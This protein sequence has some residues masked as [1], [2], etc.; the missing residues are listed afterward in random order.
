MNKMKKLMIFLKFRITTII[1]LIKKILLLKE[2]QFIVYP[3]LIIKYNPLV[4]MII[5]KSF[6]FTI[7][8]IYKLLFIIYKKIISLYFLLLLLFF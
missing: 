2:K 5:K 7:E 6:L 4:I 3:L 8:V 1:N